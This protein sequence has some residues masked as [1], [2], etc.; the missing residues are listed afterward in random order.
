MGETPVMIS[1]K[2]TYWLTE[3]NFILII[4]NELALVTLVALTLAM[5]SANI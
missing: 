2:L 4:E 3:G 1:N 5:A